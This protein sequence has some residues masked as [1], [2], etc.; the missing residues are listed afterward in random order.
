MHY[1]SVE[2]LNQIMESFHVA[3]M[4]ISKETQNGM[5]YEMPANQ[6]SQLKEFLEGKGNKK[7]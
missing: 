5:I 3:G 7:Q 2:E 1:G 4:I 6:V